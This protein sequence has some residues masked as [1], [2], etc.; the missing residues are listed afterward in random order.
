[1]VGAVGEAEDIAQE[2]FLRFH[3]AGEAGTAIQSRRLLSTVVTR[4]AIDHV[5]SARVH[6]EIYFGTWL[7]EP[8]LI[9]PA[10]DAARSI[11][12]VEPSQGC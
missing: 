8:L 7:P 11:E 5:W 4:L 3:P 2:A 12:T 10:L 6:R 9:D 1:M